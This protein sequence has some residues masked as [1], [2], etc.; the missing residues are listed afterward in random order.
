MKAKNWK[1]FALIFAIVFATSWLFGALRFSWEPAF[2]INSILNVPFGFIWQSLDNYLWSSY[3]PSFWANDEIFGMLY[4]LL[5]I[6]LQSL[7]YFV[8]VR[9][10]LQRRQHAAL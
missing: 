10:M 8:I 4:F 3:S 9:W 7:L 2:V 1:L 6:S 5:A